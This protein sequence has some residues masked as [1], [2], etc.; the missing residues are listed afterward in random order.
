[1]AK[2]EGRRLTREQQERLSTLKR[3]EDE[4]ENYQ[5]ALLIDKNDLDSAMEEMSDLFYRVGEDCEAALSIRDDLKS[6]MERTYV[7]V[8][9]EIRDSP[10]DGVKV[11]EGWVKEQTGMSEEYQ[12]AVADFNQ[13]R[14]VAGLATTMKQAMELRS[15]M[16]SKLGDLYGSGY[17]VTTTVKG[18]RAHARNKDVEDVRAAQ[19]VERASRPPLGRRAK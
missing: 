8:A 4:L 10:P 17:F 6:D 11:T 16:L 13:A 7:E 1:M 18:G 15:K 19:E 3:I 2:P 14:R 9:T 5:K 12:L